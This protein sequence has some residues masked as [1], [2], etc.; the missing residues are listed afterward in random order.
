MSS[1]RQSTKKD[2]SKTCS[3]QHIL[4]ALDAQAATDSEPRTSGRPPTRG[5][6]RNRWID[7][8]S[9]ACLST[10]DAYAADDDIC[11]LISSMCSSD[12]F[13]NDAQEIRK[14]WDDDT[15]VTATSQL[16]DG[17]VSNF[18]PPFEIG[19]VTTKPVRIRRRNSSTCTLKDDEVTRQIEAMVLRTERAHDF[20]RKKRAL[21]RHLEAWRCTSSL[22]K[23]AVPH[24][25]AK[26]SNGGEMLRLS[27]DTTPPLDAERGIN[28]VG[29]A[30][31]VV[32]E[33]LFLLL[34]MLLEIF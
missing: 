9:R 28:T 17:P 16:P 15:F 1:T 11:T 19:I 13:D 5:T 33:V 21:Q 4:Q 18:D 34:E 29:E 6:F 10:R 24:G 26:K 12:L 25:D 2:L 14:G 23:C 22:S 7:A 30:I 20:Q 32:L 3:V 31:S 27:G 8:C